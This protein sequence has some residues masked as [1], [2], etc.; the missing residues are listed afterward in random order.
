LQKV[1]SK[2]ITEAPLKLLTDKKH[3]KEIVIFGK[4][5]TKSKYDADKVVEQL[6]HLRKL[7]R[8]DPQ[9]IWFN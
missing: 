9:V 6:E 5:F 4:E 1:T 8:H 3:R 7:G 2:E